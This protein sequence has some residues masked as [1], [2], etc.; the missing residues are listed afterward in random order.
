MSVTYQVPR[1]LIEARI[2]GG[3]PERSQAT[4]PDGRQ[5]PPGLHSDPV[6][7][8]FTVDDTRRLPLP[9]DVRLSMPTRNGGQGSFLLTIGEP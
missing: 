9:L 6:S 3:L 1:Q 4:L 5:L 7:Q 2:P 8:T